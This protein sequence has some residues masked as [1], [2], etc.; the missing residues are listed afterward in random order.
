MCSCFVHVC[1]R[2]V[3]VCGRFVLACSHSMHV[4]S[5]FV[6]VC[7]RFVHVCSHVPAPSG[8]YCELLCSWDQWDQPGWETGCSWC[9]P[10]T[11]PPGLGILPKSSP[12]A[13]SHFPSKATA[14]NLPNMAVP[15]ACSQCSRDAS[16]SCIR[17]TQAAH[18]IASGSIS[19]SL[20]NMATSEHRH[21]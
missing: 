16:R 21:M 9:S 14:S 13:S 15:A 8:P 2:F 12:C 11:L 6:H 20:P 1:G 3:H 17:C 10:G 7:S 18:E 4:C 5:R 19:G